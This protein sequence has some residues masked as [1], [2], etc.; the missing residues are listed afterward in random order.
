MSLASLSRSVWQSIIRKGS[1]HWGRFAVLMILGWFAGHA[2]KRSP[3]LTDFR[4]WLYRHELQLQSRTTDYPRTTAVVVLDDSDYW[5]ADLAGRSPL[6]R[7]RL[8]KILDTLRLASVNTVVLD[9]D[10]RSPDEREV[11]HDGRDYAGHRCES[12]PRLQ[13]HKMGAH[14]I[15]L[16]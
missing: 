6:K 13:R 2:L 9:V 3:Y 11:T 16:Q 7:D 14:E 15:E 8:A 1:W 12:K 10:L 4:Y 5:G